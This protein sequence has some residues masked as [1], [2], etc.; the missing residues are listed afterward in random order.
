MARSVGD[1]HCRLKYYNLRVLVTKK[2]PQGS[3]LKPSEPISGRYFF[4]APLLTILF[5]L[6]L[7]Y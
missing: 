3:S 7:I 5:D 4:P 1:F 2:G 6:L